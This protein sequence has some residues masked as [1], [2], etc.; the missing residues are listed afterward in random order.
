VFFTQPSKLLPKGVLDTLTEETGKSRSELQ[1]RIQFA[2]R[3]PTEDEVS[4]AL[5]TWTSWTQVIQGLP[6][7][8]APQSTPAKTTA[9]KPPARSKK[10]DK[11]IELANAGKSRKEIAEETGEGDRTVRRELELDA[12]VQAEA[13]I[14]WSEAPGTVKQKLERVKTAMYKP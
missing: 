13:P 4:K 10:S 6:K 9:A 8:R 1:Y 14:D 7:T 3:Y 2:Q 12:L 5:D 11:I